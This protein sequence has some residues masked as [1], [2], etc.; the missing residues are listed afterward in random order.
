M[1]RKKQSPAEDLIDIA[2]LLPWW[3]GITLAIISFVV[4]NQIANIEPA[5]IKDASQVGQ[6]FKGQLFKVFAT[7]G[8]MIIPFCFTL[9]AIVSAIKQKKRTTLYDSVSP[10][11]TGHNLNTPQLKTDPLNNMSW[12]E[13]EMLVS[14]FFRKQGYSVIENGGG[15]ADGGV[16]IR[17]RKNN[18]NTIVQCKH[19]K[20]NK[21]GISIVREQL[22][23]KTAENADGVIIVTSGHYTDEALDFA[24]KQQITLINGP[25][26]KE[27]IHK[28]KNSMSFNLSSNTETPNCPLCSSL[29]VER[30]AKKGKYAG[31]KF[32]GCS[33]FPKC[34]E[35]ISIQ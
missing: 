3:V 10:I 9:G 15:G 23:I 20:T 2:S 7:F 26:L 30:T 31:S 12:Q 4:L 25:K 22:G 27:I 29:M 13:F 17:L 18:K 32:W 14:E 28:T 8:Q 6:A 5:P 34:R 1:A 11:E 16:D 21:V 35:T 24:N 33:K 19:W